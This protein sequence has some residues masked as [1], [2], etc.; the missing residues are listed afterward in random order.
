[1]KYKFLLLSTLVA[2]STVMAQSVKSR[3][4][5]TPERS[6]ERTMGSAPYTVNGDYNLGNLADDEGPIL[7]EDDFSS[8]LGQWSN[9]SLVAGN[10]IWVYRGPGTTP[11]S[12]VGSQGAYAAGTGVIES[13]TPQ[14]FV[15]FDSDWYDNGGVPNNF[16]GGTQPAP[17]SAA[18]TSPDID[19]SAETG[20]ILSFHS[21]YRH[22]DAFG[23]VIV[24]NDNFATS[25]T[26]YNA[27]DFHAVNDAGP[28]DEFIK[29]NISDIAAGESTVKVRF[30]FTGQGTANPTGYYFWMLDDISIK[31]AADY[32]Q[33]I[34]EVFLDGASSNNESFAYTNYYNR[35]PVRQAAQHAMTFGAAVRNLSDGTVTG[36]QLTADVS[37][38]GTF[39]AS[40]PSASYNVFGQTDT[41]N[42]AT[43][44]NPTSK[45][46]YTIDFSLAADSVDD[47]PVDN[48]I[49]K[50]FTVTER[51]YAWD[52]S[53]V[54]G[55]ISWSNGT[56]SMFARFDFRTTDTVSAIEFGIWSSDGFAS[57]D[58]SAVRVGIWPVTGG[59][60]MTTGTIDINNPLHSELVVISAQDF[61][62]GTAGD[63]TRV[64]AAFDQPVSVPAGE[65]LVGYQFQTG[66]I[67]TAYSTI[68]YSPFNAFVDADNDGSIDGW[69]DNIPI[70]HVE[71]YS[72]TY[73]TLCDNTVII[74]DGDIDCDPANFEATI[75]AFATGGTGGYTYTWS[76]G[77]TTEDITVDEE[78]NYTLVAVDANMCEGQNTFVVDNS[79]IT[80]GCNLSATALERNGFDFTVIPNPS[81]GVFNIAFESN[82]SESVNIQLQSLKGDVIYSDQMNIT[83]GTT[84]MVNTGN[85][86][87][88]VYILKVSNESGSSIKRVLI[89]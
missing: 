10:A 69:I 37:G 5:A 78:G 59:S 68:A 28:A 82:G 27:S 73:D 70:I 57:Q 50:S 3:L 83:N 60:I 51:I 29:V 16:G 79:T 7:F 15:I 64:R 75:N 63:T 46:L 1:M 17:H 52:D 40:S 58:G 26:V 77:E 61:T 66:Q 80:G 42:V 34:Q 72:E 89:Q 6:N 49:T 13:A 21:F 62:G 71:T 55:G 20:V 81:N 67:R 84:T 47:Y 86:A 4:S 2:T 54:D 19:C 44:F 25:D 39:S 23:Y 56:H 65:Y 12:M 88:G 36:S 18:L 85:I 48:S 45:G 32:D 11:N 74:V 8:G 41:V 87:N 31:G 53:D 14:H 22:Y 30:L 35:I 9:T 43:T 38:A 24:T 76:N 33:E